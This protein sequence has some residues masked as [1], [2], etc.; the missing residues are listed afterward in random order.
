MNKGY[1]LVENSVSGFTS[2]F[3]RVVA[4]LGRA[5]S[6]GLRFLLPYPR[7]WARLFG[8]TVPDYYFTDPRFLSRPE[9]L[10]FSR[11]GKLLAVSNSANAS[12]GI[13]EFQ[14]GVD[15]SPTISVRET[16]HDQLALNYAHGAAFMQDD[17]LLL[18]VGEHGQAL[19]VIQLDQGDGA[20]RGTDLVRTLTGGEFGLDNPA[21]IAVHPGGAWCVVANRKFK[22]LAFFTCS[23][24]PQD[25]DPVFRSHIDVGALNEIGLAAPHGVCFFAGG[26]RMLVTHKR[27]TGWGY[28][29]DK[30]RSAVS[31][32][33]STDKAPRSI[34]GD[35]LGS[36]DLGDAHLHHI[37]SHPHHPIVAVTNSRDVTL[38]LRWNEQTR[39]LKTFDS[40]DVFRLG[41][42]AKGVAFTPSGEFLAVSTELEEILFFR[43]NLPAANRVNASKHKL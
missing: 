11:D 33:D 24:P 37:A 4:R 31:V 22:G 36:L 34:S 5:A 13:L 12:V 8:C 25:Q 3:P 10:R 23:N 39:E 20:E 27:F 17:A 29:G 21:D 28:Q 30:G 14:Y 16:V 32:W 2:K 1:S 15:S 35:L 6:R 38:L 40:I 7:F 18:S 9:S 19:S 43:L 26:D 42:G 41:E